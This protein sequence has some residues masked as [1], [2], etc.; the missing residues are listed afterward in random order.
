MREGHRILDADRHVIEPVELWREYLEPEFRAGAPYEVCPGADEPPA[1]RMRRLGPKAV[2]RP[3][4][5]LMLDGEPV[6]ARLTE[7]VQVELRWALYLRANT[8]AAGWQPELQLQ[9]MDRA[10][11]DQGLLFPTLTLSLLA[12]EGLAPERAAAFA[13][14]YNHWLR[15]YCRHAPERLLPVGV[16]SLRDPESAVRELERVARL[17]WRAVAVLP[18]PVERRTLGHPEY[19]PV[20]AACERY[21]LAVAI[22]TGTHLRLPTAGTDRFETR[23]AQHACAHPMEQMM[24]FLALLEGGVLERHPSL[25]VAFLEAGCGWVP[26]WLWRLDEGLEAGAS[27]VSENI[28]MKPSAYFR[29]QCF[30]AIEPDEPYLADVVRHLGPDCLLFGSDFPHLDHTVDVVDRTMALRTRLSEGALRKLLWDNPARLC[31]LGAA[32][33]PRVSSRPGGS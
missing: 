15:D 10:G 3:P 16:L 9:A 17:G 32:P 24:A 2:L 11:V 27:E 21:A 12:V 23:Y 19:E 18:N 22:H 26:Y 25:R 20:W 28:R 7:R 5:T 6:A 33:E 4:P 31:G 13:R 1:E 29:R 14:A 8:L 30:V